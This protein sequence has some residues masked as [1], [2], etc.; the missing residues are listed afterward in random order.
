MSVMK[1]SSDYRPAMKKKAVVK[2]NYYNVKR[3]LLKKQ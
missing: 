3:R 1:R 2:R